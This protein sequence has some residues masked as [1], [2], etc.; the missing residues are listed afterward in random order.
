[1]IIIIICF[2]IKD[3]LFHDHQCLAMIQ[4]QSLETLYFVFKNLRKKK[5]NII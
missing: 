4:Q 5:L 3:V 2:Y 1:M